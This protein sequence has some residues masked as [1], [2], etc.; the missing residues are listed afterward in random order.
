MGFAQSTLEES[1]SRYIH[2]IEDYLTVL[3]AVQSLQQ[4]QRRMISE[5]KSLLS[6]RSKLYRSIGG[7]WTKRLNYANRKERKSSASAKKV[8]R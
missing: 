6:I 1:R 8:E 4:L 2:G 7:H 3:I 5:K